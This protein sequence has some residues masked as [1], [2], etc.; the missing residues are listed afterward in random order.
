VD[1]TFDWESAY[2]GH[3]DNQLRSAVYDAVTVDAIQDGI[4][5]LLTL[6]EEQM[7]H[8]QNQE[9]HVWPPRSLGITILQTFITAPVLKSS[10]WRASQAVGSHFLEQNIVYRLAAGLPPSHS[11]WQFFMSGPG[12]ITHPHIDPPLT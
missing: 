4:G 12:D 7:G 9:A 6:L 5:E 10:I 2:D 3:T 8:D 11:G 1:F